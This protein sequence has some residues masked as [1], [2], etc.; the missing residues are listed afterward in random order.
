MYSCE[1]KYILYVYIVLPL[2]PL[3]ELLYV[4][5]HTHWLYCT[6]AILMAVFVYTLRV[7]CWKCIATE[8]EAII[9]T[10][11]DIESL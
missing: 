3:L 2:H 4:V 5:V 7:Q 9:L 11:F 10:N 1:L 8:V 6:V